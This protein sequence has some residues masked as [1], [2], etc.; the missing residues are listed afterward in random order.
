MG[1]SFD[2][3]RRNVLLRDISIFTVLPWDSQTMG[4]WDYGGIHD[5]P[6]SLRGSPMGLLLDFYQATILTLPWL[7]KGQDGAS[8]IICMLSSQLR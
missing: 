4:H 2:F 3:H 5:L 6:W 1:R 8:P 7:Q